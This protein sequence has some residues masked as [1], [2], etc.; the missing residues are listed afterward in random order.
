[1]GYGSRAIQLL[2][3]YYGGD[4]GPLTSDPKAARA[5]AAAASAAASTAATGTSLLTEAL[6]PRIG[7]PPLL[8]SLTQR[9]AEPLHWLG[10]AFG[11]TEPLHAFWRKSG[12]HPVYLR[13]STNDVTGDII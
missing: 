2:V 7:L 12:F 1:M 10:A 4:I 11:L 3:R 9:R 5:A 13:Q 8:L 6:G